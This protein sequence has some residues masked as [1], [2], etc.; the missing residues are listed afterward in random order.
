MPVRHKQAINNVYSRESRSEIL[1][2]DSFSEGE[3]SKTKYG[4]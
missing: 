2:F 1:A 3:A 4:K